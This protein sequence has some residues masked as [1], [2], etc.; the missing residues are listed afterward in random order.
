MIILL[1]IKLPIFQ[2]MAASV[3]NTISGPSSIKLEGEAA[4]SAA[5]EQQAKQDLLQSNIQ[6]KREIDVSEFLKIKMQLFYQHIF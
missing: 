3:V 1:Y 2:S 5:K 4:R 6:H